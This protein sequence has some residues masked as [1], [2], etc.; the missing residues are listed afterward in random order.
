MLA[1]D[2]IVPSGRAH[3]GSGARV[4]EIGPLVRFQAGPSHQYAVQLR[5][6]QQ[7]GH[8]RRVDASALEDRHPSRHLSPAQLHSNQL[9]NL[10]RVIGRRVLAGADGPHRLVREHDA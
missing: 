6:G 1:G 7:Q 9:V 5:P 8:V 4:D 2:D 10:R 3:L